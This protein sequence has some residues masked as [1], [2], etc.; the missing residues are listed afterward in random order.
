M[1]A[2]IPAIWI[3]FLLILVPSLAL[4][5]AGFAAIFFLD[6]YHDRCRELD[7]RVQAMADVNAITMAGALLAGDG[8]GERAIMEALLITHDVS[9]VEVIAEDG[10]RPRTLPSYGC[11][12]DPAARQIQRPI[13][14]ESRAIG[15]LRLHYD[16]RPIAFQLR[17]E[18]GNAFWLSSF[19]LLT[20]MAMALAAL[21]LT[22]GIPLGRLLYSIRLA[23]ERRERNKVPWASR[24]ELGRVIDAFNRLL[25]TLS[26]EERALRQSEERL[27]LA[28]SATRS[29]VWDMDLLTGRVWWSAELPQMLGYAADEL[30]MLPGTL[31]SL[32]HPEDLDHVLSESLRHL[33]GET[34]S[35]RNIYR[36]RCRDGNWL[37]IEDE[38]SAIRDNNGVAIRLTGI[39][40]DVTDRK[41]V[42]LELA[43]E[44]AVLQATLENVDQGIMMFDQDQRLVTFNRRAA[45]LL[46]VPLKLLT[47]RPTHGDIIRCERGRGEFVVYGDDPAGHL[48]YWEELPS[49][50]VAFKRHR[51][52]GAVLEIRATPLFQAG[53]VCTYTDVTAEARAHQ[54]L[55][56]AMAATERAYAELKETQRNLVQ[57]EKMASLAM[58]V[59]GIAHEINTPIGIA[60]SCASHLANRTRE[61]TRAVDEGSLKRSDLQAYAHTAAESSRLMSTNLARAAELIRSFKQVAVDQTSAERRRFDLRVTID[62]IITSLGPRLR[63]SPVLVAIECPAGI[64]IDSYPGAFTQILTN[65]V[66]NALV[67]AFDEGSAGTLSIRAVAIDSQE[68]EL[69][70]ADDGKGIPAANRDRI[71]E[72]FF[73]TRRGSGGSGLGLHIVYNLVTQTLGGQ[74]EVESAEGVGTT[75]V[76]RLPTRAPARGEP[77]PVVDAAA[78]RPAEPEG[79]LPEAELVEEPA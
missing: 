17:K 51:P 22:I 52:D 46:N 56:N 32:I 66:M 49:D 5:T 42:E 70:F 36:L 73:T 43:Q 10:G 21:R 31:E 59:A 12:D 50:Y 11:S 58:L 65:L 71:F 61:L 75:F 1:W 19:L 79:A 18:V 68:V 9:C 27:S 35:Y 77:G 39:M 62:E 15:F 57:A 64:L 53:Y 30:T 23:D 37:W 3:K 20:T 16:Y 40:A 38:A 25:D 45:E 48:P 74:I 67:H 34:L 72:P 29:A 26:E 63:T 54:E 41:K 60:V 47:Q 78:G 6:R 69:R 28:I 2:R 24:D 55:R 44:R 14:S 4:V 76:L 13:V 33:A 7:A 8:A